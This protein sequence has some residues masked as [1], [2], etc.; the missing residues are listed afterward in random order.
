MLIAQNDRCGVV[1]R[2]GG[3]GEARLATRELVSAAAGATVRATINIL[4]RSV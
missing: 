3:E 4:R 2:R 1:E